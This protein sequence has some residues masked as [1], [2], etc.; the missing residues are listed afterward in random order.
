MNRL[1]NSISDLAL[2]GGA[3][4]FQKTLHVGRPN[5]CNREALFRRLAEATDRHWLTNDGP[6]LLEMETRFAQFL[7][8]KHCIAVSNATLGLQLLAFA[9]DLK[10]E[11]LMPSFTFIGT[12]R[13][14]EWQKL[15]VRFCDVLDSRHTLD[16]DSVRKAMTSEVGAILGTHLWGRP[17]EI[18]QLQAI[19]DEYGLPL[20][21]DAAHAMGSTYK[22]RRIGG[23]GRAEVFSLHATKVI[24]SL[25]GGLVTTN[26]DQLAHR[27]RLARNYGIAGEDVIEGTGINA[28]MNEYSAAMAISNLEGYDTLLA[29]N[30]SIQEA[31]ASELAGLRG[32]ELVSF[33][34]AGEH[35]EHYV[36]LR[37]RSKESG[38][39][40]D[41]VQRLLK[42]EKIRGRRYFWPGCHR[43]YP[44]LNMNAHRPLPV[45]EA[46]ADELLQ[47]PT[48]LQLERDD[49]AAIGQLI[50][51]IVENARL[52]LKSMPT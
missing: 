30:R 49:A 16:P 48:G 40:R 19:A 7:G 28:K 35:N 2:L 43:S 12:A 4:L 1:K 29:H 10:G 32:V 31:Y 6:L 33:P 24:N 46:L 13:A 20:I 44:Y 37:I 22:D 9:L 21:F 42:A 36:V 14:M 52:L 38:V 23:F 50:R 11:V 18:D 34:N 3:P 8:V 5:V 15:R 25:E 27:L 41:I 26:D 17:C 39:T 47:L 45:T 51:F